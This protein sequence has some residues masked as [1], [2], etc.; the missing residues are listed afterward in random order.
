MVDTVLI[1]FPLAL[2]TSMP[3]SETDIEDSKW[4][5]GSYLYGR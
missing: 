3:F 5:R 1:N 2:A 4:G